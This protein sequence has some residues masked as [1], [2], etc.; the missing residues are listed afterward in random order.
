MIETLVAITI[1][2]LTVVGPLTVS[3]KALTSAVE[4]KNQLIGINLGQEVIE[5]IKNYRDNNIISGNSWMGVLTACTGND[6]VNQKD[7][8]CGLNITQAGSYSFATCSLHNCALYNHPTLGYRM[9][10]SVSSANTPFVRYFYFT[11]AP[12][13]TINNGAYSEVLLT[14]VV[15]W[16]TGN[17]APNQLTFQEPINNAPR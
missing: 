9:D 16:Q 12:P 17:M 14:V 15:K 2:M 11:P 5:Y 8:T 6:P 3:S 1:M 13:A 7:T 4:A 10:S